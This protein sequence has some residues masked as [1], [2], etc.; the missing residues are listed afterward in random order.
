[1]LVNSCLEEME[2][3]GVKRSSKSSASGTQEDERHEVNK[4]KRE[5][6]MMNAV[7]DSKRYNV[8]VMRKR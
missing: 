7:E 1:M 4:V 6:M 3:I 8:A 2:R 5:V